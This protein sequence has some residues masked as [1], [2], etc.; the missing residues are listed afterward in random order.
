[1]IQ[2]RTQARNIDSRYPLGG[3]DYFSL[4]AQQ[5]VLQHNLQLADIREVAGAEKE[6]PP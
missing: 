6:R 1:L 2:E 4:A 3:F 5:R